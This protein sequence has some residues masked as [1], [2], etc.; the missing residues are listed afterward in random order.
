[1]EEVSRSF[2]RSFVGSFFDK[3][4]FI[5]VNGASG[6]LVTC[7]CAKDFCCSE[8]LIR[9]Y[10][11]TIRLK[12]LSSGTHF[13]LTNV[14][15]PST[16]E[17]KEN[18]CSELAALKSVC[19]GLWVMCGDFNLTRNKQEKKGRNWSRKVMSLF[20]N[21]INDLDLID[22]PMGNQNYTGSNMQSDPTLAKLDRFLISTEWDQTFPL[23]K[24]L[25][26]PRITSDHTPILL[27]SYDRKFGR[28]FRFEEIWLAREDFCN[29]VPSW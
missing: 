9:T 5:R 4:H 23:T 7:W 29:M 17:G 16:W 14:Y 27:S 21:L 12:H 13:F 25:A 26:L 1:M 28:T 10:S 8:V 2:L 11:L 24:V 20:S 22:L 15:G 18:F 6:G 19:P 3:C